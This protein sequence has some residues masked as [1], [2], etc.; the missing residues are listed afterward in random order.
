MEHY[1]W[2]TKQ[3]ERVNVSNLFLFIHLQNEFHLLYNVHCKVKTNLENLASAFICLILKSIKINSNW[4]ILGVTVGIYEEK[5][6]WDTFCSPTNH[7]VFCT[8]LAQVGTTFLIISFPLS[9]R[10]FG[11]N[12]Y[13]WKLGRESEVE[14]FTLWISSWPEVVSVRCRHWWIHFC[15]HSRRLHIQLFFPAVKSNG[16]V[17]SSPATVFPG[18]LHD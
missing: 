5:F 14:D 7:V 8:N 1:L 16:K 3:N 9:S 12:L 17:T 6:P 4:R 13:W 2:N 11:Q 10:P 18:L 15:P